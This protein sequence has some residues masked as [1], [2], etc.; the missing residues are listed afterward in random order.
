M[1]SKQVFFKTV[2][3]YVVAYLVL[4]VTISWMMYAYP[5]PEL[6]MLVNSQ[7]MSS[8]DTFFKY[9]SVMAEWPLYV[10]APFP[11]CGRSTR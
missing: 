6:H 7:H 1:I 3:I 4:L 9:L 11:F 2:S 10:L 8:L 5:K